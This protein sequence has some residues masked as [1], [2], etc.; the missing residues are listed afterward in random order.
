M[1]TVV[2]QEGEIRLNSGLNEYSFGKTNYFTLL[3][4]TGYIFENNNFE[5]WNFSGVNSYKDNLRTEKPNDDPDSDERVY[6]CGKNPLSEKAKSLLDF[7]NEDSDNLFK[8]VVITVT[9]MTVAA[10]NNINLPIV[11]AGGI[12]VDTDL[13]KVLFLPEDIFKY[14]TNLLSDKEYFY[15]NSG[16]TNKTIT[17]IPAICYERALIAYKLLTKRFPYQAIDETERNADILDKNFLPLELCIEGINQDFAKEINR[18]LKLNSTSVSIPGKKKKGVDS[19]D[20]TIHP[21]F[22]IDNLKE[23]WDLSVKLNI[24]ENEIAEKSANY[25]KNQKTKIEAKRKLRRN[26][27]SIIIGVCVALL[28]IIMAISTGR[29][30]NNQFTSKGLTSTE[31]LQ[32]YFQG[33]NKQNTKQMIPMSK[34]E[35]GNRL[36]DKVTEVDLLEKQIS[37]FTKDTVYANPE[38]WL[39]NV[40]NNERFS[41]LRVFGISNLKIDGMAA[42]YPVEIYRKSQHPVAVTE[43]NNKALLQEDNISHNVEYYFLQTNPDDF[44][45][46]V[47]KV[48]E[49]C[50]LTYK[51]EKWLIT[52]IS[53]NKEN[54]NVDTEKFK[55][56]YFMSLAKNNN[57]I[58]MV[59]NE[60][61]EDY[62]WLPSDYAVEQEVMAIME[63]ENY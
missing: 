24:S 26:T 23:A 6:Y 37:S 33:V 2:V 30:Q 61:R 8:A 29:Q 17:G 47:Q 25:I 11:G 51:N 42:E 54:V 49:V 31:V 50:T 4:E 10:K 41:L 59:L 3:P 44:S 20:L 12:I 43:E 40:T 21:D 18:A 39:L 28:I 27:T 36:I 1:N 35:D 57:N 15:E 19:E 38:N 34:G 56:D 14:S 53:S 13:E 62:P 32:V 52:E 22:N 46:Y 16:W 7:F 63:E 55:E 58:T 48:S 60:L 45:I 9:A 5:K